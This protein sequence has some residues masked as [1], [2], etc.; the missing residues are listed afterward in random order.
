MP[1]CKGWYRFKGFLDL[2]EKVLFYTGCTGS[3]LFF[4][5]QVFFLKKNTNIHIEFEK[6]KSYMR[7]YP[8]RV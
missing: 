3:I 2:R 5:G 8:S 4:V 1:L 6:K 7:R